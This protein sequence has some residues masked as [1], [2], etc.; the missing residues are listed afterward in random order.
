M[1]TY[2]IVNGSPSLSF[3]NVD[4][5][6]DFLLSINMKPYIEVSFMPELLASGNQTVFHYNAN[7][8]PPKDSS[9]WEYV[10]TEFVKHLEERYGVDEV[11]QWPFEIWNEPNCGFWSGTMQEYYEFYALTANAIKSVDS[12]LRVGG[13]ATCQSAYLTE[14]LNYTSAVNA[15]V[16]FVSTHEYPTDIT[17]TYRNVM[18]NVVKQARAEV[19]QLPLY[20]SEYNDG[21]YEPPHHDSSYAAAF[22]AKNAHDLEPYVDLMSWWTF[23][24]IFE[25]QGFS[26][27]PFMDP[28]G[29]GLLNRYGIAKPSYRTFQLLNEV[30]TELV[31]VTSGNTGEV[32]S[33]DIEV[34]GTIQE[35]TAQ[36]KLLHLV[37]YNFNVVDRPMRSLLANIT[38]NGVD[39]S[40]ISTAATLNLIDSSHVNPAHTWEVMGSPMYP[41]R[42]QLEEL[43]IASQLK[44]EGLAYSIFSSSSINF[45]LQLEPEAVAF[46]SLEL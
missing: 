36:G 41:T 31:S 17:P 3:F 26:S 20:Y 15:P 29:W 24:D 27:I 45:Q 1:S 34:W 46:I 5:V 22:I 43:D 7:I 38:V 32:V 25:E 16:D 28:N 13:P 14:F 40:S 12:Q 21:L 11:R 42:S 2:T 35:T 6:Y 23:S 4:S 19:G 39:T 30:G 44:P 37:V 8:T 33:K 10:I 18:T 9:A